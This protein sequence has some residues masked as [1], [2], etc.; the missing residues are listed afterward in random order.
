VTTARRRV[1]GAIFAF[2]IIC[3][4]FIG[5]REWQSGRS[6]WRAHP[7][8]EKLSLSSP[9]PSA[10]PS[11]GI[12]AG[13]FLLHD[14]A[15]GPLTAADW[16][17]SYAGWETLG[18]WVEVTWEEI[19]PA[20]GQYDFSRITAY[21]NAAEQSGRPAAVSVLFHGESTSPAQR[22]ADWTPAWVY[23][24]IP[25]R[26]ELDGRPV[27]RVLLPEGCDRPAALPLYED[28]RWQARADALLEALAR[29]FDVPER[30][31][32]LVAISV[33]EGFAGL[34]Q[35]TQDLVCAYSSQL[36]PAV[37]EGFERWMLHW[38][39]QMARNFPHRLAWL[40]TTP[41]RAP[42]R[43]EQIDTHVAG[44]IGLL[45]EQPAAQAALPAPAAL[46]PRRGVIPV[47]WRLAEPDSLSQT[48]WGL[49][50]A[51]GAG[52][53]WLD[54]PW[55]HLT[56]AQAIRQEAGLDL[57]KMAGAYVGHGAAD[58]SGVWALFGLPAGLDREGHNARALG[59]TLRDSGGW[60]VVYQPAA[61]RFG[62]LLLS[63]PAGLYLAPR[64]AQ[65]VLDL[66]ISGLWQGRQAIKEGGRLAILRLIYLDRGSDTF[67]LTYPA[68]D[69]VLASRR[70]QKEN[71][72]EWHLAEFPLVKP[73]WDAPTPFDLCI[74]SGQDGEE[75]IHWVEVRA[76]SPAELGPVQMAQV[77]WSFTRPEGMPAQAATV[78]AVA[79][80]RPSAAPPNVFIPPLM[81]VL[82]G[83]AL[84]III[85]AVRLLVIQ[86]D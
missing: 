57:L 67:L 69:G 28:P 42:Q 6:L 14:S 82:A 76:V 54:L 31:P 47:G 62:G 18:G 53:D 46:T 1:A 10:I 60:R 5:A 39:T 37:Q 13:P 44:R 2:L 58:A 45:V 73:D 50:D 19:N 35:P 27:G 43:A 12:P 61:P 66:E 81:W 64:G 26:P 55:A 25:G 65:S 63:I 36:E 21:L 23:R 4:L 86:E 22:L 20:E 16:R 83:L 68:Q 8:G 33:G 75:I 40:V 48:Y 84:G 34:D 80:T 52:I 74:D 59:L 70:V 30:Y 29:E 32:N 7:P 24:D 51:I 11:S 85:L 49:L 3:A 9:A 71:T 72:G 77:G 79:E 41:A 78:P 38:M 15:F 56:N 17:R